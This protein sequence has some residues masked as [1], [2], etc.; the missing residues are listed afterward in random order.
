MLCVFRIIALK[1]KWTMYCLEM[2]FFLSAQMK[3]LMFMLLMKQAKWAI[4]RKEDE[5]NDE[6]RRMRSENMRR[7]RTNEAESL[8]KQRGADPR[9]IFEQNSA[10][11]QLSSRRNSSSNTSSATSPIAVANNKWS[12]A[13]SPTPVTTAFDSNHSI[14]AE[15]SSPLPTIVAPAAEF[16]DT[17]PEL[18]SSSP[19]SHSSLTHPQYLTENVEEKIEKE[20]Q[21]RGGS[22]PV[23]DYSDQINHGNF[24]DSDSQSFGIR[25]RAL[26]DYTAGKILTKYLCKNLKETTVI[27]SEILNILKTT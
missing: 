1:V 10:A 11:G 5:M 9:T 23:E 17:V 4:Q 16:A 15:S 3:I 27:L 13:T 19:P 25:A 18:P 21:D 24:I 6:E 20:P 26:Y 8:I 7:Q 22:E 2:F 14:Q 12:G